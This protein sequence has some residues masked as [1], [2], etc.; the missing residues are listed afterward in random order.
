MT[1]GGRKVDSEDTFAVIDPAS[2]TVFAQ[3]PEC[4]EEQLEAAMQAAKSAFP[5]WRR[6]E[7]MR[8][9]ALAS[10]ADAI[11][12]HEE[13]LAHI[14]TREQGKPLERARGE[15]RGAAHWLRAHAELP[16]PHE[17]LRDDDSSYVEVRGVP[18]GVVGVIV[19]WN[20]PL[21]LMAKTIAPALLTGNTV[22][23]KPSPYTPLTALRLG[24]I[25]SEHLPSGVLNVV[26]GGD[27]LGAAITSH[28]AVDK[29][30]FTGSVNTGRKVA[31]AAGAD[32]KR[33]TLE[34][35]GNDPAIVLADV[36]PEKVAER[37]FWEAFSNT[38]QICIAV[39]RLYVHE[40]VF[41][42][43]AEAMS[44]IARSV[45]MG[46]G[47]N[48]STELG[49]LNNAPQLERVTELVEDAKQSG[50]T[51]LAG[52]DRLDRPGYFHQATLVTDI[53]DDVRVVAEEQ[54]GPV[55]PILPFSDLDEAVMRA[56]ATRFG[57]KASVWTNDLERGSEIAGQLEAGTT[58]VNKHGGV[59]IDVPFGGAKWSGVGYQDGRWG[60]EGMCQLQVIHVERT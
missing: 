37:I 13:E 21:F 14:L 53:D 52:G 11:E 24:E 34:L 60:L 17:V 4:S 49:P 47:M 36:D 30:A 1:I 29:I 6:D 5:G 43:L 32:L 8:R 27:A 50:A 59:D 55:L 12:A 58:S 41:P 20:Y 7:G 25:L 19:P 3:A 56:N 35:G 54:F 15:A 51:V 48:P 45:R 46:D 31:Q 16:L 2:G 38:G 57:L 18:L 42:Q 22:V 26:S 28:P 44:E 9:R 39:K 33:F 40:Q 10:C 23:L